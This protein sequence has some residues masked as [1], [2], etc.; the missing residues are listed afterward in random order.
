[1]YELTG[2]NDFKAGQKVKMKG[3]QG[4]SGAFVAQAITL[5]DSADQ[6][7]IEGL[8]QSIAY[9]KNTLRILDCEIALPGSIV[10]KDLLRN[11]I[12]LKDLKTGDRVKLIG[13][14]LESK[15][16]VPEKIKMKETAGFSVAELQGVIDR[17]DLEK[18]ILEVLGFAVA[19][20]E[21][22]RFYG[23]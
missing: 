11:S 12:A 10:I 22:T 3:R 14:Y 13:E 4:E 1:M 8:I 21:K 23:G 2:F 7:V 9:E 18:K 16:F 6:A 20:D 19:V 17:I 15:R 5:N